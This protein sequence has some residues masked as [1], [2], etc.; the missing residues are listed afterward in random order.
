MG[1]KTCTKCKRELRTDDFNPDRRHSDGLQSH[2]KKCQ[3]E[4]QL[5]YK[6]SK[7]GL[8]AF[9][10]QDQKKSSRRRCHAPPNYTMSELINWCLSQKLFHELYEEW[11]SS[12][13]QHGKPSCDRKDDYKP[14]TLDNL[15]LT[16]WEEN[17]HRCHMDT[18]NG[19][20][21]KRSLAVTGIHNLTKR[22]ISFYSIREASR[23]TGICAIQI[24]RC[25]LKRYG[26]KTAGGYKWE[27]GKF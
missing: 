20:N 2:C 23:S 7:K 22:K 4:W 9:I 24:S 17:R 11:K 12:E 14:Y 10:Y 27:Y 3:D 13:F 15:R 5:N 6:R 18:K 1:V 8:I 25:C 16:I 19:I 26:H 21:N